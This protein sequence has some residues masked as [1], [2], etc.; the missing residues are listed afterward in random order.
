MLA[1]H[2]SYNSAEA[3]PTALPAT[4]PAPPAMRTRPSGNRVAVKLLR[5]DAID[6]AAVNDSVAGSYSS[7]ELVS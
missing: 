2:G 6:A 7:A 1:A 3:R 4:S 5:A